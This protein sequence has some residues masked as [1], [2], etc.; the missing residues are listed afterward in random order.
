MRNEK[1][2]EWFEL[3]QIVE[4]LL[5]LNKFF[6]PDVTDRSA[7]DRILI[8]RQLLSWANTEK[9]KETATK[10]MENA[11]N[12]VAGNNDVW[13]L[14]D[15][16][17]S[18]LL[19]T[20]SNNEVLPLDMSKVACIGRDILSRNAEEISNDEDLRYFVLKMLEK[21]PSLKPQEGEYKRLN[22]PFSIF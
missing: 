17:L 12:N 9:K 2:Q 19:V 14:L 20:E 8:V 21:M 6:I 22:S 10:G 7:H 11:L 16:I 5:G 1:I 15:I 3:G 13:S 4:A 18:Y